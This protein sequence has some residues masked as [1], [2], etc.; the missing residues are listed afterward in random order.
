MNSI[1]V[2]GILILMCGLLIWERYLKNKRRELIQKTVKSLGL[3]FVLKG[4][5]PLAYRK[6]GFSLFKAHF[7]WTKAEN[8]IH[9]ETEQYKLTILE[10]G[11]R[12]VQ[13]L[14]FMELNHADLPEF[15]LRPRNLFSAIQSSLQKDSEVMVS[16]PEFNKRFVFYS[17]EKQAATDYFNNTRIQ[18][19]MQSNGLAFEAR[20]NVLLFYIKGAKLNENNIPAALK[21]AEDVAKVFGE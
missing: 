21:M 6:S 18:A 14:F 15:S 11:R 2:A 8:M 20:K 3:S 4:A 13:A 10:Y 16:N 7:F 12:P 9:Q 5:V 17:K 1:I 19:L